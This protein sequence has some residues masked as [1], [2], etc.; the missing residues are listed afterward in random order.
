MAIK[1]AFNYLKK[2]GYIDDYNIPLNISFASDEIL[3]ELN[4]AAERN[5]IRPD[6]TVRLYI[7]DMQ[8]VPAF[9]DFDV[10]ECDFRDRRHVDVTLEDAFRVLELQDSIAD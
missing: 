10:L 8:G 4:D 9:M 6:Y 7:E 2:K 1:A 3:E 5:G